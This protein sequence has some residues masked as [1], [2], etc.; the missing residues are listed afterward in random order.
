METNNISI[1]EL[2]NQTSC[3]LPWAE[4]H[5][6]ERVSGLPTNPGETYKYWPYHKNL[7]QSEYKDEI[8]SHTYQERIWPKYPGNAQFRGFSKAQIEA[9]PNMGIRFEFGD[10]K[11]VINLLKENPLTRQA[12]L[13]IWFPEDTWA[14]NNSKRVPCTL[15]YYFWIEDNKLHCNYIIRSCDLLRHFRNDVYLTA[16]L[17]KHISQ[18]LG[19]EMGTLTM[20]IFNLHLFVNDVYAFNKKELKIS[21]RWKE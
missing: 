3:D 13:P 20:C 21:N 1:D 12:Y 11:D 17:L 7:D 4:Y 19:K 8:F 6:L 16:R 5:F 9:S 10:L 15:G 18:E 2:A 14:A